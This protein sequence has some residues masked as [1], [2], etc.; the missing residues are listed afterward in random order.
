MKHQ[1][2][3]IIVPP[4]PEC[5]PAY[6]GD[7]SVV[8]LFLPSEQEFVELKSYVVPTA[9]LTSGKEIRPIDKQL[10]GE[11]IIRES[12]ERFMQNLYNI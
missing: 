8:I 5:K 6:S 7:V 3:N 1:S 10:P 2:N 11:D 9:A 4:E 12:Y